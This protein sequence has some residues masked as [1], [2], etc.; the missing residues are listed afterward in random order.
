MILHSQ[1]CD[2][3]GETIELPQQ[4]AEDSYFK[5]DQIPVSKMFAIS[6]D[7]AVNPVRSYES[8]MRRSSKTNCF[9]FCG[10]VCVSEFVKRSI[11]EDGVLEISK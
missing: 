1:I 8:F 11:T 4:C 5:K 2:Y 9:T 7:L 3:C 6:V 10:T